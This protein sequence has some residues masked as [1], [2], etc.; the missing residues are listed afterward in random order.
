MSL[1]IFPDMPVATLRSSIEA[2]TRIPTTS[3]H[4]YHNGQLLMDDTKTMAELSIGDGEM[5]A[6]HV[7]RMRATGPR[8]GAAGP[9]RAVAPR[10]GGEIGRDAESVRLQILGSPELRAQLERVRPQMAAV[11]DDATRFR[12]MWQQNSARESREQ[13]ERQA[14]IARLNADPFNLEAQAK[15]ADM[16]RQEQVMDNLQKALEHNPESKQYPIFYRACCL[17]DRRPW[18]GHPR[19]ADRLLTIACFSVWSRSYALHRRRGEWT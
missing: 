6:V 15:I 10:G 14:E 8:P 16:I 12:E 13:Q 4:I 1:D 18:V 11:L 7:R 3:L 5:L 19:R 9:G 17:R 2:E